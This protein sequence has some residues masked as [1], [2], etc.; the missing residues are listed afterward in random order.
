[1]YRANWLGANEDLKY[2]LA[3]NFI[4]SPHLLYAYYLE[5]PAEPGPPIALL[6]WLRAWED[7]ID[8]YEELTDD[9]AMNRTLRAAFFKRGG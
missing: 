3:S 9:S 4:Y 5:Y 2:Y 1:M 8:E 6:R 7:G